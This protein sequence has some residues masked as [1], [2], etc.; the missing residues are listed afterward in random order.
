[1]KR[2][3]IVTYGKAV[4]IEGKGWKT[5]PGWIGPLRMWHARRYA[6]RNGIEL[7]DEA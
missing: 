5:Q 2:G 4:W 7:T 1:M 6:A 3:R